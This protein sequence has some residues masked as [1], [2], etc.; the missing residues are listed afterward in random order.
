MIS[1]DEKTL[2]H[3]ITFVGAA[4]KG[5]DWMGS[6]FRKEGEPWTFLY[7]FRYHVD[8]KTFDSDDVKHWYCLKSDSFDDECPARLVESVRF[9]VKLIEAQFE[10]KADVVLIEG[11]GE[12]AFEMISARPW[13][14]VKSASTVE[15]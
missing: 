8:E 4:A 14:E 5:V 9:I 13:C 7:R 10:A 3:S 6:V 2:F 15:A 1:M 11:N 12:K